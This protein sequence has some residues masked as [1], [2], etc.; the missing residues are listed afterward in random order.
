MN[1]FIVLFSLK[2][3]LG[4]FSCSVMLGSY[5]IKGLILTNE[6]SFFYLKIGVWYSSEKCFVIFQKAPEMM[7]H[8]KSL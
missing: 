7:H 3:L 1:F 2:A 5:C 4:T 6:E 8:Q